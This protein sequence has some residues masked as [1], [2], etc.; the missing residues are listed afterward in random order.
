MSDRDLTP[1]RNVAKI[2]PGRH[3]LGDDHN[4]EGIG[5]PYITG[6]SDFTEDVALPS[7][8]TQSPEVMCEAGD[9]LITVKG[10]GVGKINFAPS[11]PTCIGRQIMAV[12]PKNENADVN[13]LYFAL[14]SLHVDFQKAATGATIPGLSIE[15]IANVPVPTFSIEVQRRIGVK[16]KACFERIRCAQLNLETSWR[17][18]ESLLEKTLSESFHGITPLSVG[19][20]EAAPPEGWQWRT[21]SDLARL[22]SGHTPSRRFPE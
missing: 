14:R 16:L 18:G 2:I 6:P 10:A 11:E 17:T 12:R 3:I 7:R 20:D 13:F 15:Q 5:V 1:L 21:L 22:E 4:R 19:R 9:I 8:W